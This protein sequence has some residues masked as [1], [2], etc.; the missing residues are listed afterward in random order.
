[1]LMLKIF[2]SVLAASLLLCV[3][4]TQAQKIEENLVPSAAKTAFQTEFGATGK[5]SWTY[6]ANSS[7]ANLD[8]KDKRV[9]YQASLTGDKG[10]FFSVTYNYK[11]EEIYRTISYYQMKEAPQQVV[12]AMKTKYASMQLTKINEIIGK[13]YEGKGYNASFLDKGNLV[14]K[15]TDANGVE[16]NVNLLRQFSEKAFADVTNFEKLEGGSTANNT[17]T[18]TFAIDPNNFSK[19]S[20]IDAKTVPAKAQEHFKKVIGQNK[21]PVKWYQESYQGKNLYRGEVFNVGKAKISVTYNE[22]GEDIYQMNEFF[23]IGLT[24]KVVQEVV[25]KTYKLQ[26]VSTLTITFSKKYNIQ[27]YTPKV[28]E[29]GTLKTFFVILNSQGSPSS[30]NLAESLANKVFTDETNFTK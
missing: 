15:T 3:V 10:R 20:K 7:I 5:P 9:L 16:N 30:E 4:A 17:N 27:Y 26:E 8:S 25:Q 29:K 21:L 18:T 22:K 28:R 11:G 23:N 1:M 19:L 2:Q 13:K 14:L 12:T 24:P 6:E